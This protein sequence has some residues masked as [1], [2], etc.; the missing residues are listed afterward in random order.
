M[1]LVLQLVDV[2]FDNTLTSCLVV[3]VPVV[4]LSVDHVAS[5]LF[6]TLP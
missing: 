4:H 3:A 1:D 6:H 2:S 5:M